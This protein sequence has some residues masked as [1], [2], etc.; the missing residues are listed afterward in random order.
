MHVQQA[1][2]TLSVLPDEALPLLAAGKLDRRLFD[3]AALARMGYDDAH[4]DGIPLI[5]SYGAQTFRSGPTAPRGTGRP[6]RRV[7]AAACG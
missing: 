3:V 5:A 4:G 2:D 6:H 7:G 1:D